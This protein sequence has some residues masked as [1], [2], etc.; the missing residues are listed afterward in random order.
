MNAYIDLH[1]TW[2][3]YIG[4]DSEVTGTVWSMAIQK[5]VEI[6]FDISQELREMSD[7]AETWYGVS[8]C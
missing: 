2:K 7:W 5:G 1:E 8:M 4:Q 6:R 3:A